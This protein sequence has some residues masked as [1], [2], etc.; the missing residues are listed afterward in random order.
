M[1]TVQ[2]VHLQA[3]NDK[4]KEAKEKLGVAVSFQDGPNDPASWDPH[5]C[6]VPSR[7][8][9]VGLSDLFLCGKI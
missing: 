3:G 6:G 4:L 5:P 8:V 7:N 9:Q 2:F 1:K